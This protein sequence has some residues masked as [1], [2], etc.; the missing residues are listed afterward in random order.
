MDRQLKI[1]LNARRTVTGTLRGYDA[2]MN[3][4]LD[5]AEELYQTPLGG[6]GPSMASHPLGMVVIRG[7]SIASMT[8]L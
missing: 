4:V 1:Q 6:Q 5:S 2:F 7:N 3:L 8:V